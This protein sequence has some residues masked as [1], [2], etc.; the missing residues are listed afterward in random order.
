MNGHMPD[1]Q[2]PH[3]PTPTDTD[4]SDW[5]PINPRSASLRTLLHYAMQYRN[6]EPRLAKVMIE[7]LSRDYS[8]HQEQVRGLHL[9]WKYLVRATQPV[10]WPASAKAD[11]ER[12]FRGTCFQCGENGMLSVFGYHVG[13]TQG[14]VMAVRHDIL[15]YI[16]RGDLPLVGDLEYTQSWGDPRSAR[17]LRKLANTLAHL[18]WDAMAKEGR[19]YEAAITERATDLR[20]L[21]SMY[22]RPFENADH[23]WD[24]PAVDA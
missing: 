19:D 23:D 15:D 14:L 21:K 11:A 2:S 18:A 10:T 7:L 8:H 24:W 9:R 16:Y 3:V 4:S 12:A 13:V 22:Y 20:Y 1:S 5:I 17:R 6:D